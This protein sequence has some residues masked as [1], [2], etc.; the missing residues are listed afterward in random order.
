M[1]TDRIRHAYA[2]WHGALHNTHPHVDHVGWDTRLVHGEWGS[3]FAN[4]PHVFARTE[5]EHARVA[6]D[7]GTAELLATGQRSLAAV[8]E[9]PFTSSPRR[10]S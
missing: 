3:T 10:Q 1:L 9:C 7:H 6:V 2:T 4:A 5:L 8:W